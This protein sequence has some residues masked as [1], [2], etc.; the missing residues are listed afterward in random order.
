MDIK[1]PKFKNLFLLS[2]L[3]FLLSVF[4]AN[5]AR[6]YFEPQELTIGTSGEFSVA[7]KID[8]EEPVNAFSIAVSVSE[9]LVPFDI[10]EANS[11]INFWLDKPN[12][13]EGTRLLTFS[14]ITPGG[15]QGKNGRFLVI[16]LKPTK[17]EGAAVLNFNK[18]K[19]KVYLHT[20]D[21]IEDFLELAEIRLPIVKGKENIPVEI[22]D[23]EPPEWFSP[24][25]SQDAN[26]FKGKWFLIFATQDKGSGIASYAVYENIRKKEATR[27]STE[28]WKET[29]SPYVLKD[30]KL[31]S[32][33]YVKA[34]D[35]AGNER[36]V[37]VEPRY[38]IK[39]YEIWWIW[40][41]IISGVIAVFIT[42]KFK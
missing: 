8:A 5:A 33:I 10:N 27:I 30:Q 22:S 37:T 35:K 40:G 2:T 25:I 1:I 28:D 18:E 41:I 17:K 24:E 29:E 31:R 15:F 38:P 23:N 32:Y 34:V 7:I 20:A 13:D 36:M 42:R 11:I 39:W 19:T 14:G 4:S 21:G 9:E 3:Y 16:K 12:W 6:L 26:L